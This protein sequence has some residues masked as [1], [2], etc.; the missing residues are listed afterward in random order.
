MKLLRVINSTSPLG[1]GPIEGI[2]QLHGPMREL[3]VELEVACCDAP[4]APWIPSSG[5][6]VIHAL[7]PGKG[8]YGYTPRL[9][10]WI[11]ANVHRF[12]A[13]VVN[14]IWQYHSLAV[15]RALSRSN[16]SYFVFT[17]GMLD[18]WF[19]RQYAL[20]HA[21]KWLYWPWAEY[22]VL[23]DARAVVF[24]SEEERVLARKS[25]WL[26]TAK[27]AVTAY[28]TFGPPCECGPLRDRFL[29]EHPELYG[30]RIVLFVG[31][32]HE[33]KGCDLLISA[34]A[35]VADRDDRLHLV[36]A[37][38]DQQGLTPALKARAAQLGVANRISWIGMVQGDAKWGAYCSAEVFCLPSHQENFGIVVAEAL[39]CG[40]PVL[41]S[42]KV[43]IWREIT[44]DVAGFVDADTE[45]GTVRNFER[46]LSLDSASYTV[47]C[48]RAHRTFQE[49]FH[50]DRAAQR[51]VDILRGNF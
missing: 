51:L 14:G 41:V 32:I 3:G 11:R 36:M 50:I 10:P 29:K 9:L 31:R 21:K 37:G 1:G 43:N 38:P 33:K 19:K 16:V 30:R 6:P 40:K 46:W 42:N 5:L 26:Y 24:T 13:V 47:M 35:R 4:D 20:K 8:K 17:H 48:K 28:G 7:G 49:R 18:P 39:A 12:D 44:S 2:K 15:R 23:R 22:R 45:D 25:F 34:F 27:E